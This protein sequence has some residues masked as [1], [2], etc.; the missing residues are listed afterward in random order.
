MQTKVNKAN[1]PNSRAPTNQSA[2]RRA[3]GSKVFRMALSVVPRLLQRQPAEL[4]LATKVAPCRRRSAI[5]V[6]TQLP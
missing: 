3:A 6:V 1:W 4:K 5:G 2:V